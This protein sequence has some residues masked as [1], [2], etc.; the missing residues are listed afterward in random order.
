MPYNN[1]FEEGLL[2]W[3]A[4]IDIHP[5]LHYYKV[6]DYSRLVSFHIYEYLKMKLLVKYLNKKRLIENTRNQ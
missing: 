5:T 2:A 4:N 1:Y 6:L 3:E